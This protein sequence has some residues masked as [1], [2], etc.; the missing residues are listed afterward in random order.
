MTQWQGLPPP[1]QLDASI[2]NAT[3]ILQSCV[4][5][6]Q[7]LWQQ[8]FVVDRFLNEQLNWLLTTESTANFTPSSGIVQQV[9][10]WYAINT[11][12]T[13]STTLVQEF[14]AQIY[15]LFTTSN[16]TA[17]I[18]NGQGGSATVSSY[19]A[20]TNT[21]NTA[22]STANTAITTANSASTAAA[23]AQTAATNAQATATI[24]LS[25]TV[26]YVF[27]SLA[28]L[29]AAT[30]I[31]NTSLAVVQGDPVIANNTMY[32]LQSGTWT[33]VN[34]RLL[35]ALGNP[36]GFQATWANSVLRTYND[37]VGTL[38][39][40]EDAGAVGNGV[41]DCGA[42]F[43]AAANSGRVLTLTPGKVYAINTSCT[44]GD[45]VPNGA[46]II[47]NP[48][49]TFTFASIIGDPSIPV[50]M[51]T[52][53][54]TMGNV[55]SLNNDYSVGWFGG[56]DA[57]AKWNYM[58]AGFVSGARKVIYWPVPRSTDPAAGTGADGVVRWSVANPL[59]MNNVHSNSTITCEGTFLAATGATGLNGGVLQFGPNVNSIPT[60][61]TF[62]NGFTADCNNVAG[63]GTQFL[64]GNGIYIRGELNFVNASSTGVLV[65]NA[66]GPTTAV[67]IDS[68]NCSGF[69]TYAL[70]ATLTGTGSLSNSSPL[71]SSFRIKTLSTLG[72]KSNCTGLVSLA[73][74]MNGVYID[75]IVENIGSTYYDWTGSMVNV[76]NTQYGT[77]TG[78]GVKIGTV[79]SMGSARPVLTT[80]D[81]SSTA[82]TKIITAINHVQQSK[83]SGIPVQLAYATSSS[84]GIINNGIP[85]ALQTTLISCSID[86]SYITVEGTHWSGVNSYAPYTNFDGKIGIYTP[87]NNNTAITL[88]IPNSF[89]SQKF[90]LMVTTLDNSYAMGWVGQAGTNSVQGIYVP[91]YTAPGTPGTFNTN[92]AVSSGGSLSG[93]TGTSGQITISAVGDT[94]Y[95][96]NRSG[97]QQSICILF[98]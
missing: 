64:C 16:T 97:N 82:Q 81:S 24:A 42:A 77:T 84:V 83:N 2:G 60:Q 50:F 36:M 44:V 23:A 10:S 73:G 91:A 69:G 65:S 39:T 18:G 87:L 93:S 88:P 17:T 19:S 94:F 89:S 54:N 43:T 71:L 30:G 85:T 29:Q 92:I 70:Q 67:D 21:A 28:A 98:A 37:K 3:T 86:C 49:V 58:S 63:T 33:A 66:N 55:V 48:G 45:I 57:S 14:Q 4:T 51:P 80:S 27:T 34:D 61:I 20:L 75:N 25:N 6:Y 41:T 76:T 62:T 46:T 1:P 35:K 5:M 90:D 13:A 15:N 11:I 31:P 53:S 40:P 52:T 79:R 47:V 26:P 68:F 12:A 78:I 9:P 72:G 7:T 56:N 38:T 8:E 74:S 96:E 22:L 32:Q 59:N 95:L